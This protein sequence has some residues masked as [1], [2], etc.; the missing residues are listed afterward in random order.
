MK[1]SLFVSGK[2]VAV[3][4]ACIAIGV[5]L[6]AVGVWRFAT[7][8]LATGAAKVLVAV[9]IVLGT[10]FIFCGI[11]GC[12]Q[13]DNNADTTPVTNESDASSATNNTVAPA[14][15]TR[16]MLN[17]MAEEVDDAFIEADDVYTAAEELDSTCAKQRAEYEA[18]LK[19]A[20]SRRVQQQPKP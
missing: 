5:L 13:Q 4:W 14:K 11:R 18:K 3:K 10:V 12:K 15:L 19:R 9:P 6:I 2:Q 8:E 1:K 16:A 17:K 7:A 20:R